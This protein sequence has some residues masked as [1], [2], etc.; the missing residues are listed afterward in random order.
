MTLKSWIGYYASMPKI[1]KKSNKGGFRKNAG[2]KRIS[3]DD[4]R[5]ALGISVTQTQKNAILAGAQAEGISVSEYV[6]KHFL[7]KS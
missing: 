1:K 3:Q 6:Q 4:T 5:T 7:N 2:R